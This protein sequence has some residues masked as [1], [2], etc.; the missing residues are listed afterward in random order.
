MPVVQDTFFNSDLYTFV[1]IPFLIFWARVFDVSI[2]T[3]RIVY[4]SKGNRL[5][6]PL[7]GFVEVLI[8]LLAI[9]QIFKHMDNIICYFA[10]AA[11]FATG[12]YIGMLIEHRLALGLEII[13]VITRSNA[14]NLSTDL[15]GSGYGVSIIDGWGKAG[16][17][18]IIFSIIKR[19]DM[20]K[21]IGI[22]NKHNPNAFYTVENVQMASTPVL[23]IRTPLKR[24]Y[25]WEMMKMDRKRK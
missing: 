24:R 13:R 14:E 23:P 2:G 21:V 17:I 11:G 12:N 9:G 5:M 3:L 19:R 1:I 6:A 25:F 10:Y 4:I 22:I 20:K 7:F 8:W 18:K 15:I 16:P